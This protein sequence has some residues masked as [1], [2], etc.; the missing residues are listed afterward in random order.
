MLEVYNIMG[1]KVRTLLNSRL[2]KNKY[3]IQWDGTNAAGSS[4]ENGLYFYKLSA[5]DYTYT[6]K[7]VMF[8]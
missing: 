4:L 7:M 6:G 2:D 3:S 8:R 1:T 5:S